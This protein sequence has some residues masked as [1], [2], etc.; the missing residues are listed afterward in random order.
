M[1]SNDFENLL[2]IHTQ[3]VTSN[4]PSPLIF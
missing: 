2:T 1:T 4:F 3:L